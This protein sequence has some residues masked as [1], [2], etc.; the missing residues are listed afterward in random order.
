MNTCFIAWK[1]YAAVC[2]EKTE[3]ADAQHEARGRERS[4]LCTRRCMAEWRRT[5]FTRLGAWT[6]RSRRDRRFH[7]AI[8][9][10]WCRLAHHQVV[11]QRK[12]RTFAARLLARKAHAVMSCWFYRTSCVR[13]ASRT[14]QKTSYRALKAL[15]RKWKSYIKAEAFRDRKWEKEVKHALMAWRMVESTTENLVSAWAILVSQS[16]HRECNRCYIRL[17]STWK[18]CARLRK[19]ALDLRFER[20]REV[21]TRWWN[22]VHR[23]PGDAMCESVDPLVQIKGSNGFEE[24]AV[25]W[26]Q[27][28]DGNC[29]STMMDVDSV[30]ERASMSAFCE[31]WRCEA[32]MSCKFRVEVSFMIWRS[33]SRLRA[34][35][36]TSIYRRGLSRARHLSHLCL[37]QWMRRAQSRLAAKL[38]L[39]QRCSGHTRKVLEAWIRCHFQ[40]SL[41]KRAVAQKRRRRI[42]VKMS[43]MLLRWLHHVRYRHLCDKVIRSARR[44]HVVGMLLSV[45]DTWH[46]LANTALDYAQWCTHM[47]RRCGQRVLKNCFLGMANVAQRA[48]RHCAIQVLIARSGFAAASS[49]VI[50]VWCSHIREERAV[51]RMLSDRKRRVCSSILG[52][53]LALACDLRLQHRQLAMLRHK[54][55]VIRRD[56]CLQAWR[57]NVRNKARVEHKLHALRLGTTKALARKSWAAWMPNVTSKSDAIRKLAFVC[58][59]GLYKKI[60]LTAMESW[61][62]FVC[63]KKSLELIL[64]GEQRRRKERGVVLALYHWR[65]TLRAQRH[66]WSSFERMRLRNARWV[67]RC[68]FG[69]WRDELASAPE[70][71]FPMIIPM[72]I[73]KPMQGWRNITRERKRLCKMSRQ[74][75]SQRMSQRLPFFWLLWQQSIHLSKAQT[76]AYVNAKQNRMASQA[77]RT[78]LSLWTVRV[79]RRK[80]LDDWAISLYSK[81][82]LMRIQQ[83]ICGQHLQTLLH[84]AFVGLSR[85]V[86][87]KRIF[88][89][90]YGQ[91]RAE[92][93]CTRAAV[94]ASPSVPGIHNAGVGRAC[95][96]GVPK[97]PAPPP[98]RG[99]FDTIS[100]QVAPSY[101]QAQVR[102]SVLAASVWLNNTAIHELVL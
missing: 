59:K 66:L 9:A 22:I 32:R 15:L 45:L 93:A 96:T 102:C 42:I 76:G 71:H 10:F 80:T 40:S 51:R 92:F 90:N 7:V 67:L 46:L 60:S 99:R 57:G 37:G 30:G 13:G 23:D 41:L 86:Q 81:K 20:S 38:A 97:T 19:L 14:R 54:F 28:I 47:H 34:S 68:F 101:L 52:P 53:W 24:V 5:T 63:I 88:R 48:K 3:Q 6:V 82:R 70:D 8:V 65:L 74:M 35:I 27:I 100:E 61:K 33:H 25:K 29:R 83:T 72:I 49:H 55:E 87:Q 77:L 17:S 12:G 4:R 84:V 78:S 43:C 2:I 1:N 94:P 58:Q 39:E 50:R 26:K 31:A 69:T 79:T 85:D 21:L 11:L 95:G 16:N 75:L 89:E 18:A 62:H 64:R 73:F 36:I 91:V 44:K 56:A 98:A